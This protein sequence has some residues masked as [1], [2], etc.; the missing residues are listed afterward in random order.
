MEKIKVKVFA[1]VNLGL[2]ILGVYDDGYHQLKMLM[3]SVDI[4]DVV[5][6][7]KAEMS[8]VVMD[9]VIAEY[10]NTASKALQLLN[11]SYGIN[12][13]VDIE[14]GIPMNAG[15]GGS[16]ADA[17]AVFWCASKL[18]GIS[19]EELETLAIAVGSDVPYM[20]YGGGAVVEGR[21]ESIELCPL[22]QLHL[23]VVQRQCGASTA[24]VYKNYD[25]NPNRLGKIELLQGDIFG[26]KFFNVLQHSAIQ[27][28]PSI[29]ETIAEMK[30]FTKKVFMSGSGSAVVGVFESSNDA[31]KACEKLQSGK[32]KFL[33][34]VSTVPSGIE[35]IK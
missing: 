12:M 31:K 35:V 15:L 13:K 2:D 19:V 10:S 28:C 25:K 3:A 6:C 16:S 17:A 30:I 14:K 20:L 23:I 26:N 21:G 18:Y 33:S 8:K 24:E 34:V 22:P 9:G 4:A 1:K 11:K 5:C 32:Y 29:D 27:L 7:E